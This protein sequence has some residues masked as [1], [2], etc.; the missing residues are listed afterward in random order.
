MLI[1]VTG[2]HKVCHMFREDGTAA[3]YN[4]AS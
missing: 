2:E 3:T 1:V 4:W